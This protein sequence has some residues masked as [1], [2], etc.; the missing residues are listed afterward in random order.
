MAARRSGMN[1]RP[2]T[3]GKLPGEV[4]KTALARLKDWSE[5]KD[6]DA[7]SKKFAFADSHDKLAG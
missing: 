3:G 4:R 1:G 2:T 5:V 7:I 6:R